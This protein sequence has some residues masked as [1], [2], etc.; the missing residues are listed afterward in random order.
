MDN[1][2]VNK[3][4]EADVTRRSGTLRRTELVF[5]AVSFQ[6]SPK[7]PAVSQRQIIIFALLK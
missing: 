5:W 3:R 6:L 7:I 4:L 1:T 2:F